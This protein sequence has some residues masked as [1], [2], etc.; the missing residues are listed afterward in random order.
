[1]NSERIP[2]L[3]LYLGR[4]GAL[5]R[6]TLELAQTVERMP[7]I[8][9]TF[10]LSSGNDIVREFVG[11]RKSVLLLDTFDR[12]VSVASAR[13]FLKARAR[14]LER[15]AQ[16]RPRAVITLMPHV[17]TPLLAR[18]IQGSGTK[19]ITIIHDAVGH[20]GDRT[21]LLVPWL[22]SEAYLADLVV[23]LSRAVADKLVAME[24]SRSKVLPLFHPDLTYGGAPEPR[25]RA[26]STPLRLLF[27]GR[28][29]K[30]KGLPLLIDAVEALQAQG[31]A[32]RLGVAGS[33]D[34]GPERARLTRLG[35]E[36]INRW[37]DDHEIGPLLARYDAVALPH[38]E[39]SQS[40]VAAAAFG[41]GL[42]VVAMPVGGIAEQVIDAETGVLA[43]EGS[44]SALAAAIRRLAIDTA[45]YNRIS[46]Y[47]CRT[48][49]DR[50]MT[51]F[52]QRVVGRLGQ[53]IAVPSS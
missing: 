19:Y 49:A 45:L 43:A 53:S 2:L 12:A 34:L 11:L 47:L 15:I 33:G 8:K 36:V 52:V 13:N 41:R 7:D 35:A 20:P 26:G 23:T 6:F 30:Y 40:G 18:A 50:S 44:A 39:A 16:D 29:M 5:G 17:W 25:Q 38:I 46:A 37:L 31:V 42:P 21:G 51:R 14:L 9:A 10:A 1:M 48:A 3:F 27:F 22:R 4:R 24:V 32:V 28:I